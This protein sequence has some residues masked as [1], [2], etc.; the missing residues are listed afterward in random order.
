M[1]LGVFF[2]Y[3]QAL[4]TQTQIPPPPRGVGEGAG[5]TPRGA[6]AA[7]YLQIGIPTHTNEHLLAELIDLYTL[8]ALSL[9]RR[10]LNRS[11][12]PPGAETS[13]TT[14]IKAAQY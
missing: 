5:G 3:L 1:E 6:Y 14:S 11:T 10:Q 9:S 13:E 12:R 7:S 4:Q 2:H 8:W